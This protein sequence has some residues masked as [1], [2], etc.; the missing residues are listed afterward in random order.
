[1][2]I[3]AIHRRVIALDVHQKQITACAIIETDDGRPQV[4]HQQFGAFERDRTALAEWAA[5]LAPEV[6]V[7]E[8]T[9]IYW[10]APY[11]ALERVG[12][13]ARVVNAHFVKQVPG[14]KTDVSDAEWLASLARCGLMTRASFVPPE[15]YRQLRLVARHR[16]KLAGMLSAHKNRFAKVLADSGVRLAVVVSDLNGR[17]ARA[18]LARLI[19]GA[20]AG[21]ALAE[22]SPRLKAPRA[23]IAAALDGELTAAHRFV[24]ASLAGDIDRLEAEIADFDA[25]LIAHLDAPAERQA[26]SILQTM[27][28]IDRPGAALLLVEIGTDMSAFA[29]PDALARWAGVCPPNNES[30]GKRKGGGKKLK[31]NTYVRRLLCEFTQAAIKSPCAFKV[32]YRGLALRRGAKRAVIACA[33]KMLR[34]IHAMLRTRQPYRDSTVDIEALIAKRN[35]P[36]WIKALKRHGLMPAAAATR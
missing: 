15:K 30:A 17:S 3:E 23:E 7:M 8:S 1:M 10:K 16:Q 26:L 9:G 27:P 6:V 2:Q 19:D 28:G 29:S 5:G 34:A 25:Y 13:R 36:R 4:I 21:E 35:A 12:I 22:A 33:H 18:M 31:G 32:K 11:A 20:D 24:L 14:R